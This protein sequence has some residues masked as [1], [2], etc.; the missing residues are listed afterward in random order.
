MRGVLISMSLL[1][2]ALLHYIITEFR[3]IDKIDF[4]FPG[5]FLLCGITLATLYIILSDDLTMNELILII[6]CGLA[7]IVGILMTYNSRKNL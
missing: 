7:M 4:K 5:V 2:I 6:F 1:L 3:Q